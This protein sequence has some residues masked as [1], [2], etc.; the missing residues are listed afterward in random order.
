FS[1]HA[2]FRLVLQG[3]HQNGARRNNPLIIPRNASALMSITAYK[4]AVRAVCPRFPQTSLQAKT[5]GR[6]KPAAVLFQ[7]RP[8][9]A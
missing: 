4:S 1:A 3:M 2:K 9:R 6:K 5:A 8:K 7:K